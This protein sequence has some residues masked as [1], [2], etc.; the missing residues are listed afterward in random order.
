MLIP[1]G[2]RVEVIDNVGNHHLSRGSTG[3]VVGHYDKTF[4]HE[5]LNVEWDKDCDGHQCGGLAKQG[6][7]WNVIQRCVRELIEEADEDE[8]IDLSELL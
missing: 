3:T 8:I 4:S 6:H 7:G 5:V 2:A 1:I